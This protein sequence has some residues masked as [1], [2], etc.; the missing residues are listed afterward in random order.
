M[1]GFSVETLQKGDSPLLKLSDFGID[2]KVES[3]IMNVGG[4]KNIKI[5]SP[6]VLKALKAYQL[7]NSAPN[8]LKNTVTDLEINSN[9]NQKFETT[10]QLAEEL[11]VSLRTVQQ[12]IANKG[13]E[14][15]FIPFQTKGGIQKMACVNEAQAT[16]IKIELQ[17]HSKVARNGYDTLS[18]TNDLEMMIIQRKLDAYKDNRIAELQKENEIQKQQI[19][20]QQKIIEEQKPNVDALNRI[21]DGKGCYSI[22]QTAKALK[23]PYGNQTLFKKLKEMGILNKDNSPKQEQINAGHFKTVIKYINDFVGN[24]TI[25]LTTSK[26]LVYLAKRFNTEIDEKIST[27]F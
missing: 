4:H 11:G 13:Y 16:A 10:K 7:K 1:T 22:N 26:G 19:E 9:S 25:T 20:N 15:N 6:N 17:N 3:K 18:I 24:K 23:L 8:A 12:T 5:Y 14:I 21:A 2:F 27:D